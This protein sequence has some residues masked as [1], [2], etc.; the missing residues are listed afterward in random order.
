MVRLRARLALQ[1]GGAEE[2]AVTTTQEK[3]LGARQKLNQHHVV[4]AL[5]MAA[6]VGGLASSWLVFA[7]L[8]AV[9]IAGSIY[10]GDIRPDKGKR[11]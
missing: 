10:A 4:G 8:A 9:L 2:I 6:I 5:G 7:V 1:F 11:Q 3:T